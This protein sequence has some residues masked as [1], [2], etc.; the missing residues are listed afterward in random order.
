MCVK[1]KHIKQIKKMKIGNKWNKQ[2][3]KRHTQQKKTT[4]NNNTKSE[5]TRTH[6]LGVLLQ[7]LTY[8]KKETNTNKNN[9]K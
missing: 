8:K 6:V 4:F 1:A 7:K 2:K 5:D 3:Q 9:K